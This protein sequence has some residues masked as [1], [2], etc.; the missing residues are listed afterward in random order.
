MT[1]D[2][3][4]EIDLLRFTA[5]ISVVLF[6]YAFRGYAADGL[7][8]MPYPWLAPYAKY[9]YLGVELFFMI[10]G[11]VILMTA[12]SGSL[13]GFLVSRVVRLYPA[14][15][16]C[17]TITFLLMWVLDVPRFQ[18]G[19]VQYLVNLTMMS[20]FV[21][22]PSIDNVYW[23]LFVELRFYALVAVILLL[24]RI[25]HAQVLLW[26]W[27]AA[28]AANQLIH[29]GKVAMV[30]ITNYSA[31]FIAGAACFLIWSRG[32]SAAR[33]LLLAGAW[34]LGTW[35]ALLPLAEFEQHYSTQMSRPA[36]VAIV[37]SCFAGLLLVSLRRT[38]WLGRQRWLL[39]GVL[40]Y[41]LYLLHQNIGF[42][43]FQRGYPELNAH[44]LL[45]GVLA[46][47]CALAY[48][49]HVLVEKRLSGPMKRAMNGALDSLKVWTLRR[50]Q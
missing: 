35:Q 34:A 25:G 9:G 33:L 29:S 14:F 42:M 30:L 31:F 46:A 50:M 48:C 12:S 47:M 18:A 38:G 40:T 20:G 2:R 10:S 36:V 45:W 19:F 7:S 13:R 23:S 5:A 15:W 43:L 11:F 26:L 27:L 6:H 39:G 16:A 32:A 37:A 22:V 1:K 8:N 44:V 41:P 4:N 49:V 21:D 3:V 17:C 24:G 28:S